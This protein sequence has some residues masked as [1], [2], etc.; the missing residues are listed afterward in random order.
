[1]K[2][3]WRHCCIC[4]HEFY[5]NDDT[6]CDWCGGPSYMLEWYPPIFPKL[7]TMAREHERKHQEQKKLN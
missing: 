4:H 6:K 3:N 5:I 7:A 2:N 1:M